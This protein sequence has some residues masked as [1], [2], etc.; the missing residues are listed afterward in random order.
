VMSLA[1]SG[2][3]ASMQDLTPPTAF[4]LRR[5]YFGSL[6]PK[7]ELAKVTVGY[8]YLA[9]RVSHCNR[10]AFRMHITLVIKGCSFPEKFERGT[11]NLLHGRPFI[12]APALA[13]RSHSISTAIR[14]AVHTAQLRLLCAACVVPHGHL[15]ERGLK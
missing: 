2:I 11:Q 4:H 10:N 9:N 1:E 8:T 7:T 3:L 6:A 15:V 12:M 13:N 14:A 5:R